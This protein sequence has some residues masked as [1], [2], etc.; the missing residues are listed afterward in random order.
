MEEEEILK[1]KTAILVIADYLLNK[2][3]AEDIRQ[4]EEMLNDKFC[5]VE[6]CKDA[7]PHFHCSECQSKNG[8]HAQQC[9]YKIA[10]MRNY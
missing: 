4:I 7:K 3:K 5:S 10:T 2:N 8:G 9:K 6:T 1:L